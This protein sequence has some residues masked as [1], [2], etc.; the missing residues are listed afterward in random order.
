MLYI[1][2]RLCGHPQH[3]S[4]DVSV[5]FQISD[6]WY[7]RPSAQFASSIDMTRSRSSPHNPVIAAAVSSESSV[8]PL[9]CL[10]VRKTIYS[11]E[12]VTRQAH[13]A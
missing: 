1:M 4:F 12:V 13:T 5:V 7:L 2:L 3:P 6:P 11:M 10:L 9:S 8:V